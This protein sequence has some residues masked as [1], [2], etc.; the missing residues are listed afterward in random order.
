MLW[1][2]KVIQGQSSQDSCDWSQGA[3][4]VHQRKAVHTECAGEWSLNLMESLWKPC[5]ECGERSRRVAGLGKPIHK[6]G[7][8]FRCGPVCG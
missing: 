1:C 2:R 5:W 3:V 7:E 4:Q 8:A 6:E